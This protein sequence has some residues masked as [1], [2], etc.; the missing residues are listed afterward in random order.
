MITLAC[1]DEAHELAPAFAH[2]LATQS[3]PL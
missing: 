3:Y 1:D 2:D